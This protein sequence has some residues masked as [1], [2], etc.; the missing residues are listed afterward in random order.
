MIVSDEY[1]A[2]FFDGEGSVYFQTTG[3]IEVKV[4]QAYKKPLQLLMD[5]Y[6][7]KINNG[8][9]FGPNCRIVYYWRIGKWDEAIAFL[10]IIYP[11]LIV[12]RAQVGLI[13]RY[14]ERCRA[15]SP[16]AFKRGSCGRFSDKERA[17]RLR[18][19]LKLQELK[20]VA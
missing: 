9:K 20:R 10:R 7:G 15:L 3:G 13:L 14:H 8:T 17:L 1:T 18:V 6:G 4:Y 12:K 19:K 11:Y 5:K 16:N 2:G